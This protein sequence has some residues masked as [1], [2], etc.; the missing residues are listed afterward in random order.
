MAT[1][2]TV[3]PNNKYIISDFGHSMKVLDFQTKQL[4][5]HLKNGS[6]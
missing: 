5:H 4:V 6:G 2:I 3:T 1:S